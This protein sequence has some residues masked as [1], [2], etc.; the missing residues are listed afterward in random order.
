MLK[1][2]RE[3]Y[4][5]QQ[6]INASA[7]IGARRKRRSG[8]TAVA[9][10]ISAHQIESAAL[11]FNS[12]PGQLAEQGIEAAVE[13]AASL[14]A[15][16]SGRKVTALLDQTKTDS[17]FARLVLSLTMNASRTASVVD[18]GR[19]PALTGY[20]RV[21][22]LPS[23]SRC[24][25]LAGRFYRY[26]QGF[27]RHPRCDC[28]MQPSNDVTAPHLVTDP[29][30]A[31]RAGQVRGL[32]KADMAAFEEGADLGRI[33]NVRR[34]SAGLSVGSSVIS[35]AGRLTPEG[36]QRIASDR[37]EFT[38]LLRSNGYIR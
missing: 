22:V 26:S 16:R 18:M 21:L 11:S 13:G 6:R 14:S 30:A 32:S 20:V 34:Q 12:L 5:E 10:V 9:D 1:S 35:R 2:S 24:A 4:Q 23:C 8:A 15:L 37:A 29:E 7:L 25:I 31:V 19:R 28:T 38:S 33:V 36:I 27:Q 3:Q 17:E